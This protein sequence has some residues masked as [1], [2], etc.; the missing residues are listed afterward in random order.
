MP[1]EVERYLREHSLDSNFIFSKFGVTWGEDK[2]TIPIHDMDGKFLYNRYRHL[3]GKSKFTSDPGAHPVLFAL[4]KAKNEH[5]LILCEGE[6][7]CMRLWQEDIPAV[8][9]TCGVATFSEKLAEPLTGKNVYIVLDTDEP[10]VDSVYKYIEILNT[11]GINPLIIDLPSEYKDVCEYF[12]DSHIKKDFINLQEKALSVNDW[13]DKHSPKEFALEKASDLI[14]AEIP[15]EQWLINRILPIE[16]FCFLV[17]AEATSKTFDALTMANSVATGTAWLD[18]F[19]VKEIGKVLILDKENTRRRIQSRMKGLNM[20]SPDIYR[21]SYPQY[22]E[23]NDTKEVDG[24]SKFAKYLSR[25]V[26]KLNIKLIIIDSFTDILIGNENDREDVQKFFDA[27]RQLFPGRSILI[28]HHASKPAQG[29]QRTSAQLAR[30]STNIMAQAYSAFHVSCMPKSRTEFVIEQ[31]KA[32]DSEKLNKFMIELV[33]T[34]NKEHPDQTIVNALKY[35]GEVPDAK[36]KVAEAVSV[37]EE[38]FQIKTM[39]PRQELLDIC[40]GKGVSQASMERAINQMKKEE[41]LDSIADQ[42]NKS[43][44]VYIQTYAE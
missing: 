22:F 19:E 16:G 26:N 27:M 18:K 34:T 4:D 25:K 3:S 5:D 41:R 43:K 10:G 36:Q 12:T 9:G 20:N 38:A 21:V 40:I 17:G 42:D 24:Y 35:C 23:L 15:P 13:I 30:G 2:I 7:D 28:L 33:V 8:T 1:D 39:L 11:I 37:I 31:T 44:R 29:V 6:P 14:E 32:G